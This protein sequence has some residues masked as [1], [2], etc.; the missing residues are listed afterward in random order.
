M[1]DIDTGSGIYLKQVPG[2]IGAS[3]KTLKWYSYLSK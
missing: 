1:V 2:V 3:I